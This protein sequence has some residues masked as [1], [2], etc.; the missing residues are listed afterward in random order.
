MLEIIVDPKIVHVLA[1][2]SIA[3]IPVHHIFKA[4]RHE[5]EA[6]KLITLHSFPEGARGMLLSAILN[7]LLGIAGLLFFALSVVVLIAGKG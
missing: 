3:A 6:C 7:A 5:R 4:I 2:A 1:L